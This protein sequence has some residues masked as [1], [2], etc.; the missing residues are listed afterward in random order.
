ML[1]RG[2]GYGFFKISPQNS[3]IE[4]R[5]KNLRALS[6]ELFWTICGP[7]QKNIISRSRPI[8]RRTIIARLGGMIG[9]NSCGVH[10][11]MAG[12]TVENIEELE[13]LTYDGLRMR[14]GK[15][16]DEELEE[17]IRGRRP[18]RRNLSRPEKFA[19]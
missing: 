6:R 3:R 7:K 16:S 12:K 1:Q 15:T 8:L 13:V 2:R 4:C 11:V 9:N 10:S 17:I 19:R 5:G 14:V 18:A